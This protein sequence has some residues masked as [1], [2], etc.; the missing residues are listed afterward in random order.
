[1]S[2]VVITGGGRGIGA[3]IAC[4]FHEAGR[5][6]VLVDLDQTVLDT[7]AALDA[8]GAA[9]SRGIVADVSSESGRAAVV[10]AV[11]ADGG[12]VSALVNNAGI[13][14]DALIGKMTEDQFRAVLRVNLGAAFELTMALVPLM[15]EGAAVVSLSSK[16]ANGNVGQYNYAVS[17]AGLL[18]LTRS[19]ALQLAPAVRVNAVAPAFIETDMTAA[20]PTELRERFIGRI[21]V[22]RGGRPDEVADVVH[23]LCSR[24]SS[25]VTGQCVAICGGRSL[26]LP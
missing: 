17:K 16:S 3:A 25:Y 19:L 10:A 14:R 7:A 5:R 26:S 1:M 13:T 15:E 4:R 6:T 11:Q 23:A 18:G 8:R 20:I 22:G 12:S 21:P 24:E 9:R 2:A